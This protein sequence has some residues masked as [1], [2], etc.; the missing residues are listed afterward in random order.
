MASELDNARQILMPWGSDAAVDR[1]AVEAAVAGVPSHA[2][3]ATPARAA[4][5]LGCCERTVRNMIEQGTLLARRVG[6]SADPAR[7]H[8][9][10][11]VRIDRP[12]DPDRKSLLSLEEA[13]KVFT[14][15]GG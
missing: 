11:I 14:N 1:A 15:I 10:V 5:A 4:V 12:F 2:A 8:W 6:A 7:C 13:A 9:R 3:T